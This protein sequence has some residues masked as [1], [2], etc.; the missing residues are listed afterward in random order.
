MRLRLSVALVFA[1]VLLGA[2][3]P[4]A[5][6]Q[7][8][9]IS[10]DRLEQDIRILPDGAFEVT[11]TIAVRFEGSWNGF[12]RDLHDRHETAEGRRT[13]LRYSID[14]VTDSEGRALEVERSRFGDGI[15]LRIW[16]PDAE[17]AVRDVILRYRVEG[18]LRFWTSELLA[19]GSAGPDAPAEP[20]DELYWN[21]TGHGWEMSIREAVVRVELPEGATGLQAWGYTGPAGSTGQDVDITGSDRT[22]EIRTANPLPPYHGLTVSVAWDPGVIERP[23]AMSNALGRF[24]AFWPAGLPFAMLLGMF[25]LWKRFG[26]DPERRH[27]A[28]QYDPPEELSP[29]EAGTL[30]DH[31]AEMHDITS[32]LVDLAVRGYLRIEEVEKTGLLAR[33]SRKNDYTFHRTKPRERW[34][35]LR[36]HEQRYLEGLFA[37]TTSVQLSDLENK[38]YRHIGPITDR[39]YTRLISLGLYDRRPDRAQALWGGLGAGLLVLAIILA[40][41]TANARMPWIFPHPLAVGL[42]IGLSAIIILS[43]APFMGV[44]TVE[45]VRTLEHLLG[46]KEFLERV[47]EDR[48]ARMITSPELFERYLPFALAFQVE[49]RWSKAFDSLYRE[50][51]DWYRGSTAGGAFR[52]SAFAKQM[53]TISTDA[54]RSMASSPSSSGSGS[55]GGGSSGGGSGGGGGRGF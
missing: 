17:D 50:P 43:F 3:Q 23:G 12:E 26:R 51:P 28:V 13:R 35:E 16:V 14:A 40:I 31:R 27:I 42:G 20:F 34:S 15:R 10:L 44:R 2:W 47:E 37:G 1:L 24:I 32:T 55:G 38:F 22:I 30:I 45:G 11:E 52:A 54:G 48:F 33:F 7:D 8:R 25:R 5:A 53:R 19:A 6:G 46:F 49:E 39:I 4:P 9:D 41:G 21:A 36:P 29:A 18:G